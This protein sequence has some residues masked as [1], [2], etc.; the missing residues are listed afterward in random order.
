MRFDDY[1]EYMRQQ[2][3]EDPIYLFDPV[4]SLLFFWILFD[5]VFWLFIF[6]YWLFLSMFIYLFIIIEKSN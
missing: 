3:D 1:V 6:I 4:K 2:H 5:F